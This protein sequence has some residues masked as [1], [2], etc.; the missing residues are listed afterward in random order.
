MTDTDERSRFDEWW[1]GDDGPYSIRAERPSSETEAAWMAW[2]ARA[3]EIAN[4][5]GE[6]ARLRADNEQ[7]EK[8]NGEIAFNARLFADA[9]KEIHRIVPK[10]MA[11]E[12]AFAALEGAND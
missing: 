5:K 6:V 2:R 8:W 7:L 10:H 12:I 1:L 11:G 9:L 3:D 4:L